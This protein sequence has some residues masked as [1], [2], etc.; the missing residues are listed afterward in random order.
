MVRVLL[1]RRSISTYLRFSWKGKETLLYA[2]AAP[3]SGLWNARRVPRG[4]KEAGQAVNARRLLMGLSIKDLARNAGVDPRTVADLIHA[5]RFAFTDATLANIERCLAW[6]P[7]SIL[8]VAEE[9]KEPQDEAGLAE[10][11][12]AWPSLSPELRAALVRIVQQ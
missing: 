4:W 11:I 5:R 9:G 10:V 1:P 12:A 2:T 3:D 7:G 6:K 8:M